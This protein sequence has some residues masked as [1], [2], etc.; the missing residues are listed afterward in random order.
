MHAS[1]VSLSMQLLLCQRQW[2]RVLAVSSGWTAVAGV[3]A[4]VSCRRS[5]RASI[6]I[7]MVIPARLMTRPWVLIRVSGQGLGGIK[8]QDT[9]LHSITMSVDEFRFQS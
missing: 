2:A 8:I 5:A 9:L 7:R 6:L 4:P 3:S 1:L